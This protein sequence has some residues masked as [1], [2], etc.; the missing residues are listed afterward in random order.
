M[1]VCRGTCNVFF[2]FMDPQ[3]YI[4]IIL[5]LALVYKQAFFQSSGKVSHKV[6]C[7]HALTIILT[8]HKHWPWGMK[9]SD[10]TE[11]HILQDT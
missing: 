10:S 3:I 7:P 4:P 5:I 2:N 8:T 9:K 11:F 6:I 1:N